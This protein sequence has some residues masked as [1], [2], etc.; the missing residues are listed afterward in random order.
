MATT[1][2]TTTDAGDPGAPADVADGAELDLAGFEPQPAVT[3]GI[4]DLDRSIPI[5]DV[6][7]RH[8][9]QVGGRVRSVRV[10]AWGDD[11]A[12]LELVLADRTGGVTVAFLG[13]R[14]L[15][16]IRPGVDLT[17]EGMVG[18]R[19][20]KLLITNPAYDLRPLP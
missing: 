3:G 12:T 14:R 19:D 10:R 6:V 8:R 16:G 1:R 17:V 4:L 18:A 13:R 5:A 7:W 11:V 9:A 20:G 15:G 2:P